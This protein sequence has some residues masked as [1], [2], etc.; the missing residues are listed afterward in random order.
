MHTFKLSDCSQPRRVGTKNPSMLSY[1][2]ECTD[3]HIKKF[4]LIYEDGGV[5]FAERWD[6][7]IQAY[8]R[9]FCK[10]NYQCSLVHFLRTHKQQSK[11][12]EVG[13]WFPFSEG[14]NDRH[15]DA[16]RDSIQE[17][18]SLYNLEESFISSF[19]LNKMLSDLPREFASDDI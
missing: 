13:R 12:S 8:S 6:N 10:V 2:Q 1:L 3:E 7:M 17:Q 18:K 14:K 5:L 19:N 4:C 15:Y 9:N 16:E 11:D